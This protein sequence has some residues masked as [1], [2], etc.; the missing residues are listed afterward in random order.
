MS[1]TVPRRRTGPASRSQ[2]VCPAED[3]A[4]DGARRPGRAAL[5]VIRFA[6]VGFSSVVVMATPVL[7][8]TVVYVHLT[9]HA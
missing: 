4:V 2:R 5:L 8:E 1:E 9:N 6:P 7:M 3:R